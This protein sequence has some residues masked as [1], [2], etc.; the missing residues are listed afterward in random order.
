MSSLKKPV[1]EIRQRFIAKQSSEYRDELE[2]S[3]GARKPQ[4]V[5]D[6]AHVV[7]CAAEYRIHRVA[8]RAFEKVSTQSAIG[9]QRSDDRFNGVATFEFAFGT[10]D[11]RTLR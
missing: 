6:L 5:E 11:P 7:A 4:L 2:F 9:F 1:L 8:E 3:A 10:R